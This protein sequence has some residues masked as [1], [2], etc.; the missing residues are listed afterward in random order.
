M[1]PY[2]NFCMNAPNLLSLPNGEVQTVTLKG[3]VLVSDDIT[4]IDVYCVPSFQVNL[5]LVSKLTSTSNFVVQF[6]N[7]GASIFDKDRMKSPS[8]IEVKEGL[9]FPSH[10]KGRRSF[11]R[12]LSSSTWYQRLGH[13]SLAKLKFILSQVVLDTSFSDFSYHYSIC[14]FC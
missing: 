5:L 1:L 7:F 14:H 4:S 13:T 12:A 6:S 8:L 2:S 10:G 3:D 11:A 9:Y